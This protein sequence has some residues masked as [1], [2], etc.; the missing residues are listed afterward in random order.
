M[1]IHIIYM[2]Y[3][4]VDMHD[5]HIYIQKYMMY[6]IIFPYLINPQNRDFTA[7]PGLRHGCDNCTKSAGNVPVV[8][9]RRVLVHSGI[10]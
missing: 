8:S 10:A 9:I 2:I 1:Y 5:I 7:S 4:Y 6:H 3:I